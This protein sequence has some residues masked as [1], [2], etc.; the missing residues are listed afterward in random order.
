MS[1]P[2]PSAVDLPLEGYKILVTLLTQEESLLWSRSQA[3][4]VINGGMVTILGLI[5]QRSVP[6]IPKPVPLAICLVGVI[7][8][9]LWFVIIR[10]SEAFYDHWYDQLEYLEK[11]YLKPLAIFQYADQFFAKGRIK[12]GDEEFTLDTLARQMRIYVATLITSVIF[13]ITWAILAV[14]ISLFV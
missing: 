8:C 11:Q 9:A 5:F 12:L 13:L 1:A 4:L 10:R 7:T 3:F 6:G 14:Y 2:Q